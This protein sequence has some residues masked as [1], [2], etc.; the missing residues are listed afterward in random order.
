MEAKYASSSTT[1]DN[2]DYGYDV[3]VS[4]CGKDTKKTLAS[5]LYYLLEAHGY[6]AFL[7][8]KKMRTGYDVEEQL[9]E[10]IKSASCH[11]AIFS[12]LYAKSK[13]CLDELKFMLQSGVQII[14]IF[15]RVEHAD[16]QKENGVYAQG[17]QTLQ[18]KT[19]SS[20]EGKEERRYDD[21]RIE[22]WR[23][24]LY[25]VAK[26][27][28]LELT[29][30]N[31]DEGCLLNEVVQRVK[32]I[33]MP[34]SIALPVAKYPTGL[35]E[36]VKD[37][38]RNVL[39]QKHSGKSQIVGIT[40]LGG[41]GKTTLAKELFNINRSKYNKS[42][43]FSDVRGKHAK[44]SLE[45]LQMELLSRF[46]RSESSIKH[47]SEGI[48]KLKSYLSSSQILLVL[49]DID[50]VDQ[51]EALLPVEVKNAID[52][53]SLILITTRKGDVLANSGVE[54]QLIYTLKGLEPEQARELF[55]SHAFCNPYPDQSFESLV[56]DFVKY[57]QGLPL[58]L[59][60]IGAHLHGQKKRSHWRAELDKFKRKLPEGIKAILKI[61]YDALEED[62]KGIFLDIAC[63][64][65]GHNK[66]IAIETWNGSGSGWYGSLGFQCL[67]KRC[68]V[69]VDS[70]NE[71]HMHDHLRDLGR[72]IAICSLPHRL[73]CPKENIVDLV[74]ESLEIAK[75]VRGI[76]LLR[77]DVEVAIPSFPTK[78]L[79]L[80]DTEDT[81]LERVCGTPDFGEI[82][83]VR[84]NKYPYTSLPSWLL[85][86]TLRVLQVF[87]GKL[88][89]LWGDD[90][91]VPKQLRQLE[92]HAPI[93]NIPKSIG[94]LR[95][96]ERLVLVSYLEEPIS[97]EELPAEF[98]YLQ[99]LKELVLRKCSK[100]KSLPELFG[101]L[102]NLE[103]INLSCCRNLERFPDSFG[104]LIRLKHLDLNG[105]WKLTIS[106]ITLKCITTL[107]YVNLSDCEQIQVLP[108]QVA[109]QRSLKHLD[110]RGTNLKE[111]P[112]S[113]GGLSNLETLEVG[114]L[115][116]E[117][118]PPSLSQL[119]KLNKFTSFRCPKLNCLPHFRHLTELIV[120]DC[121][122][123]RLNLSNLAS[124][125]GL[126]YLELFQ[127]K[128]SEV[129]FD[130]HACPNLQHIKIHYCKDLVK[131]GTLP[132]R[133]IQLTLQC[134]SNL[135]EI[136]GLCGHPK[137]ERLHIERCHKVE[138]LQGIEALESLTHLHAISCRRLKSICG[139][140]QLTELQSRLQSYFFS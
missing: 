51:L 118:L 6:R 110:L 103:H 107:E 13:W 48:Q 100:I 9:N 114:N 97:L 29:A 131:V 117:T 70:T 5:H 17:L 23:D 86:Q 66:Q 87:G 105:C 39:S 32:R 44:S 81:L 90:S 2:S 65:V 33:A 127:T 133:L 119:M 61:S 46:S 134:C 124:C 25:R 73:W 27:S 15:Y 122:V 137:L 82:V 49:D 50:D 58:S 7:D 123:R 85:A 22:E 125:I 16:L 96:L 41:V 130:D 59:K 80:V 11:V 3:F 18:M 62:E 88:E 77:S 126:Q 79:K 10:V 95:Y 102:T 94:Q 83:W 60:V 106:S 93:C 74:K 98:C 68:L 132:N 42:V 30:F 76:R 112:S 109:H 37:F 64:F 57:C 92:I 45:E 115:L 28:G 40:G 26:I 19:D 8:Q 129:S 72:D 69:E 31:G 35:K 53:D 56:D 34:K 14:P 54:E 135:R 104:K 139:S 20:Q 91:Q 24:A 120:W 4:H 111:L 55:C 12:P 108:P 1:P 38:E 101:N 89:T 36:K 21:T 121:P 136:S 71:I 67:E 140:A 78:R 99:S 84:W 138:Q 63:F 116:L 75:P 52:P 47:I 113:V 43:F 128:M